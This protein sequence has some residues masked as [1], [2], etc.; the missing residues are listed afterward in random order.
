MVDE[1][2]IRGDSPITSKS[3]LDKQVI[4][5]P[6]NNIKPILSPKISVH[7][8]ES[9]HSFIN[10]FVLNEEEKSGK[11]KS[12]GRWLK[13]VVVDTPK[14]KSEAVTK[15]THFTSRF[16]V[17]DVNKKLFQLADDNPSK[18]RPPQSQIFF[19]NRF[20]EGVN[21]FHYQNQ[22]VISANRAAFG[23]SL[24]KQT[25]LFDKL[26]SQLPSFDYYK[27]LSSQ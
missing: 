21:N 20:N 18:A 19:N 9:G 7:V 1:D 14:P 27:K 10:R 17:D 5:P 15:S 25:P 4:A 3:N 16:E 13:Q 6:V 12:P 8:G 26:K 2:E 11:N 22:G 23:R 24:G